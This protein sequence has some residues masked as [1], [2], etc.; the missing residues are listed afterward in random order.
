MKCKERN[1]MS[2][3]WERPQ[4]PNAPANLRALGASQ[5][6]AD[7][8]VGMVTKVLIEATASM[9]SQIEDLGGSKGD[10]SLATCAFIGEFGKLMSRVF[11]IYQMNETQ[12]AAAILGCDL[13]KAYLS[14]ASNEELEKIVKDMTDRVMTMDNQGKNPHHG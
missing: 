13:A 2:S 9:I 11:E 7:I 5:E 12:Y 8:V 14:G 10:V 4:D 3:K 6:R 1:L